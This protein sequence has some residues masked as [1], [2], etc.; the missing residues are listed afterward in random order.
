MRTRVASLRKIDWSRFNLNFF[1]I[2]P[3]GA[4][5][6]AP[7]FDVVTTRIP[8]GHSS[9]ELQRVLV[10]QFPNVTAIDLTLVLDTIRGILE[11]I[12]RVISIL[13]GFTVLAGLPILVGTLLN[14]RDQRVRESVLLRTLGASTRQIRAILVIEYVTLGALSALAGLILA[15]IANWALARF[16]FDAD[17]WP[18]PV[19]L[20]ATFAVTTILALLS[21]MALSRGVSRHPPL[22]ILRAVA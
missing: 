13:A 5:E 14:G 11:K 1:M 16:V 7:T 17:P 4:L 19:L 22:E 12:S 9:G 8:S 15:V 18:S 6:D 10:H 2:F 20:G 21:G 3:P